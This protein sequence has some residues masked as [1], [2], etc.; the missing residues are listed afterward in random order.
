MVLSGRML[1]RWGGEGLGELGIQP[2][3]HLVGHDLCFPET[4]RFGDL[5][6]PLGFSQVREDQDSNEGPC[7]HMHIPEQNECDA[8]QEEGLVLV[9]FGPRPAE[10]VFWGHKTPVR[11]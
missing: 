6:F 7:H 2:R 11:L 8:R 3:E 4:L 10:P 5:S 1:F 9:D